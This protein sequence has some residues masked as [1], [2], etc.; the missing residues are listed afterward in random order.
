MSIFLGQSYYYGIYLLDI[1]LLEDGCLDFR[2]QNISQFRICPN[3]DQFGRP[4]YN[5]LNEIFYNPIEYENGT[6]TPHQVMVDNYG[7]L[8]YQNGLYVHPP[9]NLYYPQ[10]SAEPMNYEEGGA[11]KTNSAEAGSE[12][13]AN[14]NSAEAGSEILANPEEER[15]KQELIKKLRLGQRY[16]GCYKSRDRNTFYVKIHYF[17]NRNGVQTFKLRRIN[18][19]PQQNPNS[20]EA[21]GSSATTATKANSQELLLSNIEKIYDI[22]PEKENIMQLSNKEILFYKTQESQKKIEIGQVIGIDQS[23]NIIIDQGNSNFIIK[24]ND[25]LCLV[26][27]IYT[28][29]FTLDLSTK[30]RLLPNQKHVSNFDWLIKQDVRIKLKDIQIKLRNKNYFVYGDIAKSNSC[31]KLL[32]VYGT[33]PSHKK[34]SKIPHFTL[35]EC[36][37]PDDLNG[38]F[39]FVFFNE[40]GKHI[41]IPLVWELNYKQK[42]TKRVRNYNWKFENGSMQ[43]VKGNE[44]TVEVYGGVVPTKNIDDLTLNE[45]IKIFFFKFL[46]DFNEIVFTIWSPENTNGYNK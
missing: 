16:V 44:K 33:N 12:I 23:Y 37:K 26:D 7:Y 15:I 38:Q 14:P 13:L 32:M 36:Y 27:P 1:Y 5:G 45:N 4:Y 9:P 31:G 42:N 18:K 34:R 46:K 40:M 29:R 19:S 30:W 35:H 17:K 8:L 3:Y 11:T 39:H 21:G 24:Y 2:Y 10:N 22:K 28:K 6:I 25:V 41:Y 20:T 43:K